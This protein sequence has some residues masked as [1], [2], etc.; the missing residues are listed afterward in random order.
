MAKFI[1]WYLVEAESLLRGQ[2]RQ[3]RI[4]DVLSEA[5]AHLRDGVEDLVAHGMS[6]DDA[7]RAAVALAR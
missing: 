5:E 6:E 2:L 3:D 4:H 7:R 1:D